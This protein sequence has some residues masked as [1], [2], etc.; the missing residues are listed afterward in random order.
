MA[1]PSKPR[2]DRNIIKKIDSIRWN[3]CEICFKCIF[4]FI[5]FFR[6]MLRGNFCLASAR[7]LM[8]TRDKTFRVFA[9]TSILFWKQTI[10]RDEWMKPLT[11]DNV[12]HSSL[13]RSFAQLMFCMFIASRIGRKKNR[14]QLLVHFCVCNRFENWLFPLIFVLFFVG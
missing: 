8:Q 4:K 12:K 9:L 10:K 2:N 3:L 6:F 7:F 14:G 5:F 11:S 1:T 13:H